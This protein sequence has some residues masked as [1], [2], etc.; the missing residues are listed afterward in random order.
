MRN[1][2]EENLRDI[3][4]HLYRAECALEGL[5]SLVREAQNFDFL[6]PNEMNGI[7]EIIMLI[8]DEV[9]KVKWVVENPELIS[10]LKSFSSKV[11]FI[12]EEEKKKK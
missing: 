11:G 4:P 6:D 9:V 8:R 3:S 1:L 12:K 10:E 7:S 2:N 5:A